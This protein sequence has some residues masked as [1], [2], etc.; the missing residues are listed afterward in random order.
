MQLRPILRGVATWVPGRYDPRRQG[1]GGTV[2]ARYCYSVWLRHLKL[3]DSYG[4]PTHYESV[5]EL[6]P[7]DSL[8]ISVA[9]LLTGTNRVDALDVVRYANTPHNLDVMAQLVELLSTRERI[10]DERELPDVFPRL[11]SYAFPAFLDGR[12]LEAA[13]EDHRVDRIAKA[14]SGVPSDISVTYYVP[15]Q[16]CWK[17]EV[18]GADLVI[19]QA[20]LEHVED[21]HGV[22]RSLAAG[23]RIGGIASHVIDF[24][25]HGMTATWDGHLEYGNTLWRIVKGHRPFLLN[26]RSPAEH[27]QAMSQSGFEIIRTERISASPTIPRGSLN[28]PF[29]DWSEEDRSTTTM[30]V[31]ARRVR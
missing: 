26:R 12:R 30:I 2:S 11:P 31:V 3:L 25:S 29:R 6:G 19:S 14:L 1:T 20:A 23:L 18:R 27:L 28:P 16:D 22:Q 24:R 13:L 17:P 7:G 10:P 8:G 15:W 9:A 21:I 5:A 4:L